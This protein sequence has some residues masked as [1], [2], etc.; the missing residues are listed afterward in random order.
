MRFGIIGFGSIGRRHAENLQ[1]L[2]IHDVV[3]LR[4]MGSGNHLDLKEVPDLEAFLG[5]GVDQVILSNPTSMHMAYLDKLMDRDIN[6]L[7]EKPLLGRAEEIEEMVSRL[8]GYKGLGMVAYNMRFHPCI[9][10]LKNIL[11][12][13][14]LGNVY[15]ARLFVGQYLP[16]W[17]PK[18]DYRQTYSA[19]KALGGGVGLDLIHEIDLAI[20][21]FGDVGEHF[22]AMADRV[23]QLE[24]DTEDLVEILYK[25]KQGQFVSIHL[26]YLTRGYRRDILITGEFGELRVDLGLAT[27]ELK[28]LSGRVAERWSFPD[29]KKNDMY[30]DLLR[31]FIAF[32]KKGSTPSPSFQDGLVSNKVAFKAREEYYHGK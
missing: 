10:E 24:I 3:L 13:R 26:D 14:A 29:F 30:L 15:S 16:D 31:T 4:E 27:M 18:G 17:R 9:R 11:D 21:L 32:I 6:I 23:S 7:S 5:S 22:F 20:H 2:G 8:S 28:D 12:E 19:L 25:S 1:I